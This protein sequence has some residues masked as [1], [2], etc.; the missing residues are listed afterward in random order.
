MKTE[1]ITKRTFQVG[2][3][4]FFTGKP[5]SGGAYTV[6]DFL[7]IQRI[8]PRGIKFTTAETLSGACHSATGD[9]DYINR[10]MD[11]GVLEYQGNVLL[12]KSE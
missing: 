6:G 1:T 10:E 8:P 7:L 12:G 9:A 5:V 3:L 11:A 2:D 4:F